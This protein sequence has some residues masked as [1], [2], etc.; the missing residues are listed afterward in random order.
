M[1]DVLWI[2]G[3]FIIFW[4]PGL[5]ITTYNILTSHNNSTFLDKTCAFV[6]IFMGVLACIAGI[7]NENTWGGYAWVC[8]L[9]LVGGAIC[10]ICFIM[11]RKRK[12]EE[13]TEKEEQEQQRLVEEHLYKIQELDKFN[14]SGKEGKWQFPTEKF[15]QDC[16]EK[17]VGDVS[18][19]YGYNKAKS[20]AEQ[21]IQEDCLEADMS[22]FQGYLTKE[23]LQE[24]LDIGKSQAEKTAQRKLEQSK[25]VRKGD[26]DSTE[27]T[28]MQRAL[29][30][31]MLSG[32]QKRIKMLTYLADD[33]ETEYQKAKSEEDV[34][35]Q[36]AIVQGMQQKKEKDWSIRAGAANGIAGPVAGMATV[37][38]TMQENEK[39]RMYNQDVRSAAD[40]YIAKAAA[41]LDGQAKA[42]AARNRLE[43]SIE[44]AKAVVALP[45]PNAD[46]LWKSMKVDY[47]NAFI[48]KSKSGVLNVSVDIRL[49]RPVHLDV[50]DG[51]K[52]VIDG[53]IA[54]DVM[55][56]GNKIG[57]VAFLLPI[58][59]MP[60]D[61]PA[62]ITLKGMCQNSTGFDNGYTL[63]MKT[64]QNLWVM[65][66]ASNDS[67]R[68]VERFFELYRP[69]ETVD[70]C[71]EKH[72]AYFDK[73]EYNQKK[74]FFND[75]A[76][77]N[78]DMPTRINKFLM[79]AEKPMTLS[80]I[81]AV[82]NTSTVA[83]TRELMDPA[84]KAGSI[85]KEVVKGRVVY[86]WN[87][88]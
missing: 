53:T 25:R 8:P 15:Y 88:E 36:L 60:C 16:N 72:C 62:A 7:L 80:E 78:E 63:E 42:K 41:T 11:W 85:K 55:Y 76:A 2:I 66:A 39:I 38:D 61:E 6:G 74:A 82:V 13:K 83:E 65:E 64:K 31:A 18:S 87:G 27:T 21:L 19:E 34:W 50:P 10:V 14:K 70:Q 43:K 23:K 9:F 86:S 24:F 17:K 45:N 67:V 56:E 5:L 44:E 26:A 71:N 29:A 68:A 40:G 4:I 57:E 46:T 51:V 37:L 47:D 59:G 3:V 20:I 77:E 48:S 58:L 35:K 73:Y 79:M 52:M 54:A 75:E 32:C 84:I 30:V 12:A 22:C 33:C 1:S 28:F 81:K 49:I 69:G